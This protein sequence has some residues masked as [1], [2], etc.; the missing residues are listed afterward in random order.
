VCLL[1][2][3]INRIDATGIEVMAKLCAQLHLQGITLHI[4]G[5]KL[6]VEAPLRRAGALPPGD[7]LRLYRTDAELLAA[8]ARLDEG[9]HDIAGAAI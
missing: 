3:P 1:A 9:P 6:P 7:W 4:S 2:Q 8:L 5:L